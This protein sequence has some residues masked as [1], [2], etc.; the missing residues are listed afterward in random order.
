[1]FVKVYFKLGHH[2]IAGDLHEYNVKPIGPIPEYHGHQGLQDDTTSHHT[3]TPPINH[4]DEH[5]QTQTQTQFIRTHKHNSHRQF[6]IVNESPRLG[7]DI[8][9]LSPPGLGL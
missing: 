4:K 9:H 2:N 5:T 1:M 8:D 6:R 3:H 7:V